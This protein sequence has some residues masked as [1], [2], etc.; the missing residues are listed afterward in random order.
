MQP[1]CF[2]EPLDQDGR[3]RATAATAGPW[4]PGS[5]HGGPPAALLATVIEAYRPVPGLRLA[6]IA[7]ELLRPVPVGDVVVTAQLVRPGRRVRLVEATL[8]V[9]GNPVAL[10][11][12]WQIASQPDLLSAGPMSPPPDRPAPGPVAFF[13]GSTVVT[14]YAAAVEWRFVSGSFDALGPAAV[15]TRV[16]IPL[17]VGQPLSGLQRLLIAADSAN[18]V[19]GVLPFSDWVFVPTALTVTVHRHPHG[20]WVFMQAETHLS[21]DGIG[22]CLAILA[23]ADGSVGT[24]T[25][26]LVITRRTLNS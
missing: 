24:A 1:T 14:G 7:V 22:A 18:G 23:D 4:D 17:I 21:D 13:D 25:Q 10:A 3:Y 8:E 11:R 5:Q 2:Y 19:S 16:R 12:A 9:G 6:R 26:P 15:W 20:Q